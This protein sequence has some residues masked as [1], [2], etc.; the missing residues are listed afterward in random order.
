MKKLLFKRESKEESQL[1]DDFSGVHILS[2]V[3]VRYE[4]P[5]VYENV[6]A[7]FNI[8]T[9]VL[10]TYG[11]TIYNPGRFYIAHELFEHEK[12]HMSQQKYNDNDA[13]LWWGKFLRDPIFRLD[14]EARAYGVQ[15]RIA[16]QKI[17]DREAR[18]RYLVMIANF[19]SGPIYG[20]CVSFQEALIL[21]KKYA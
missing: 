19:L 7:A 21:I 15:Y 5:P 2:G 10:F 3:K 11:D 6:M 1:P 12:L 8:R 18:N 20:H 13:A 14:Q 17:T 4:R 9:N 16:C